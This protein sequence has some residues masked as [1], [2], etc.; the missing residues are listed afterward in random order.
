MAVT[1]TP[2]WKCESKPGRDKDG[3]RR[4]AIGQDGAFDKDGRD[5]MKTFDPEA[6]ARIFGRDTRGQRADGAQRVQGGAERDPGILHDD[7]KGYEGVD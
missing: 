3:W 1:L 6:D 7:Y 4:G 5:F 2:K